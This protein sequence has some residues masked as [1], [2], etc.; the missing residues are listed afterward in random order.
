MKQLNQS[1]LK[2]LKYWFKMRI[3][4]FE[5]DPNE[6]VNKHNMI[7]DIMMDWDTFDPLCNSYK[8]DCYE[9]PLGKKFECS[10]EFSPWRLVDDS[11]TW[12]EWIAYSNIHIRI[13]WSMRYAK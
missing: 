2:A 7:M 6:N 11:K 8:P 10:E 5:Q 9:C 13:L 3:W 4:V 12:K 1:I